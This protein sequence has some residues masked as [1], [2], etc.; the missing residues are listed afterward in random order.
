MDFFATAMAFGAVFVPDFFLQ[1]AVR[2]E[3]GIRNRPLA[4]VDGPAPTFRVMAVN[5]LASQLGL[6]LGLTKTAAAEFQGVEIR[7]RRKELEEAAHAALLDAAWSVS[8]RVEDTAVDTV[9]ID[10]A[11]LTTLFGS[12]QNIARQMKTRCSALGLGVHVAISA[13][14]ETARVLAR[15][16]PGPTIVPDGQEAASLKALPVALLSP[17][18]ELAEVLRQW[19]VTT[20][21]SLAALP[22]LSLS[23]CTGQ[24]G[25]RLQGI[26]SGN[27]NRSLLI[28]E[29][30]HLFEES[31][32]LDDAVEELEPLSFLLG[33]LLV[34]LCARLSTRALAVRAIQL[35][36]DL[37]PGFENALDS[38]RKFLPTNNLPEAFH[39]SL[40]LPRPVAD[41]KLL[42]KLLRLRLAAN[43]PQ[44]PIRK[45]R[46]GAKPDRPTALQGG[47]FLPAAPD[48]DKLELTLARLAAVVGE[49]HVGS[50]VLLDSHHLEAFRMRT[51]SAPS[52]ASSSHLSVPE[53]HSKMSFRF[54]RPPL[55]ANVTFQGGRP[56]RILFQ[57]KSW[58]VMQASGPWR[59]SGA[60][61]EEPNWQEDAWDL[62]LD[63]PGKVPARAVYCI[64]FDSLQKKWSVRGSYD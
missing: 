53:E 48:P 25:V 19:G 10:L 13:N 31:L 27:G 8:P 54:V 52:R 1:A 20:C 28:A 12:Y 51:F 34:Q 18:E 35:Q 64:V 2:S 63:L 60:W 46:M 32:E 7:P 23:E 30:I 37:E 55:P 26:A 24:E 56:V 29:P 44:A 6:T 40:V 5:R 50:P 41:A 59:V 36:L 21:G 14:A 15:A 47:L 16:L 22:V 11:G 61:W 9:L 3:P 58:N 17:G 4:L 49:G 33:R 45:L 39:C 43:P 57:G 62:E 42:L 38:S